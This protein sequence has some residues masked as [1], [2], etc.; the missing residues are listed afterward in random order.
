MLEFRLKDLF[1]I[2]IVAILLYQTYRLLRGTSAM[3][4]F[5]SILSFVILWFFVSF[6]FQMELLGAI[7]TMFVNVGVVLLVVLFQDEIRRFLFKAGGQYK[8]G[9]FASI[10]KFFFNAEQDNMAL[11]YINELMYACSHLADTKTGAL[12]VIKNTASLSAYSETGENIDAQIKARLVENIFFKNSPLHD[13]ALIIEDNLIK[14]VGC[15]LPLSHSF[16]IPKKY[17]LRHRAAIGLTEKT[18]AIVIVISEE[19][20]KISIVKEGE[21]KIGISPKDMVVFLTKSNGETEKK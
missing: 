13:G 8:K 9:V 11:P 2:L 17:G 10:H 1:D 15:I 7:M 16:D 6:V 19:S 14:S 21:M 3:N 12:I 20:G 4:V 5:A 18:D